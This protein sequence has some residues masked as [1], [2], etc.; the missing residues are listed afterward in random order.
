[1]R[2]FTEFTEAVIDNIDRTIKHRLSP[3]NAHCLY[4]NFFIFTRLFDI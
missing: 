2:V 3:Y 4:Y 1:M